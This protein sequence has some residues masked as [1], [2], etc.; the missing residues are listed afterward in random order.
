MT[1]TTHIAGGA[2]AGAIA[3]HLTGDP[4]VGTVIGAIAGLFPDVDHPG[5]L[6]G[7]R[8]RPIAVLLEVMFGH[9]SVTHTVWFCLGICLLVGILAGIVNGFLVPF[10][11]QGL[12]V[13][14]ISMSVGAGALSHLALDALTRSGI[15][16]FLPVPL[17][18]PLRR[19]EHI[20]GPLTTGNLLSEALV[21]SVCWLLALYFL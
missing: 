16:P 5:S 13:S 3:G 10:G 6:V 12:S 14:L 17:P 4:V 20:H 11:I 2:L 8:L 15:R 19:L 7:R 9:R 18:D 21:T 1:G